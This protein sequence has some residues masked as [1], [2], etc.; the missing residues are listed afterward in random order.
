MTTRYLSRFIIGAAVLALTS[1]L[2]FNGSTSSAAGKGDRTP[3]TTPTNLMVTGVT[4]SSIS[5]SWQAAT[6]NSGTLSYKIQITN[7]NNSYYNS[8]ATVGQN[9]T[10][11]IA[12]FLASNNN[13]TFTVSAV[14][15]NGNKSGNSNTASGK[16][17]SDTTPPTGMSL[18]ASVLGPSQVQLTWTRPTDSIPNN[19]CA[20]SFLMNGSPLTQNINWASA[21]ANSLS[22]II[23]HLH[24]STTNSFNVKASDY[25]GN[26]TTS[27]TV[28]AST[29]PSNDT[30]PPSVPTNLHLVS[31]NGCAEV[32]L[33][34]NQATD[35]SDVQSAIEY[36]IYVNDVLSPLPVSAGID[37]DFVYGTAFGDNIFTVKAVDRAGNTSNASG[38]IKLFLW[39]C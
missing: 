26:T 8:V 32:F 36:E 4:D 35:E 28:S 7:L 30:T 39:P 29:D 2:L 34:W 5:L 1:A 23:R 33:G 14:D 15:G 12:R 19:C 3:P 18:Q 37:V 38:P 6:D 25:N 9:Q 16:T 31:E 24:P 17:L 22:V 10:T 27:N 20:Y 11:Y 13:Y 21:P